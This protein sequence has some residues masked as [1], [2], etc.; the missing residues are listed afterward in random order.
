MSIAF[1]WAPQALCIAVPIY[2]TVSSKGQTLKQKKGQFAAHNTCH[3][4]SRLEALNI[5]IS[6]SS[7]NLVTYEVVFHSTSSQCACIVSQ[8]HSKCKFYFNNCK[9]RFGI[10]KDMQV[11]WGLG[12]LVQAV[13]AVHCLD[14]LKSGHV[15]SD[16]RPLSYTMWT[17]RPYNPHMKLVKYLLF[18]FRIN[19]RNSVCSK[20]LAFA[21]LWFGL[22]FLQILN[23]NQEKP[24]I[25]SGFYIHSPFWLVSSPKIPPLDF[26]MINC[27]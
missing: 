23:N 19:L 9:F 16:S 22:V 20:T 11:V 17:S 10:V 4:G 1:K 8:I 25:F 18:P 13:Q 27:Y 24:W 3:A 21:F 14:G 7:W 5:L 12:A 26:C 2:I 6:F 15:L